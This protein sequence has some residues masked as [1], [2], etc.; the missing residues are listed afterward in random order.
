MDQAALLLVSALRSGSITLGTAAAHAPLRQRAALLDAAVRLAGH[1][2]T[3]PPDLL[4]APG[5]TMA[6]GLLH[7]DGRAELSAH[8]LWRQWQ[9]YAFRLM[10]APLQDAQLC[11]TIQQDTVNALLGVLTVLLLRQVTN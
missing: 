9:N 10:M 7:A 6:G 1:I 8:H 4:M 5:S 3:L 11:R 2:S